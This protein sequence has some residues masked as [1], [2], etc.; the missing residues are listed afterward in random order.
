M[1]QC[2][3]RQGAGISHA[4]DEGFTPLCVAYY[5]DYVAAEK[6]LREQGAI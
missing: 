5:E 2:L 3:V 1:V 6:Y 4:A